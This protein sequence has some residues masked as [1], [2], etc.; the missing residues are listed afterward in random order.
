MIIESIN[1][2]SFGV[3]RDMT[4]DFSETVNVI[5]GENESGKS[6][7]ASFMKYMLFGFDTE[8]E[9]GRVSERRKR[10]NWTTETAAGTMTVRVKGK[11]YLISRETVPTSSTTGR[12]S[13]KEE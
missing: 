5:E 4:L 2:K 10:I 13:Y 8:E 3:L 9:E 6:T 11:R 1:I 7:L 12:P